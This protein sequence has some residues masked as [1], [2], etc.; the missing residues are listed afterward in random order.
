[1]SDNDVF[2]PRSHLHSEAASLPWYLNGTLPDAEWQQITQHLESCAACRAELAELSDLQRRVRAAYA[3]EAAPSAQARRVV[4]DAV[5]RDALVRRQPAAPECSRADRVEAW[6][7]SLLRPR[8]APALAVMFLIAQFG[9]LLW[10]VDRQSQPAQVTSRGLDPV[11]VRFRVVFQDHTTDRE[12]RALLQ[13]IRGRIVDGPATDGA[14]IVGVAASDASVIKQK[15]EFL[16]RHT[17]TIR[18]AALQIP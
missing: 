17:E 10:T 12:I 16:R 1:M 3:A 6:F 5:L 9:L 14:Y 2:P 18:T 13:E 15:L 7:R 4:M 11:S 8:W